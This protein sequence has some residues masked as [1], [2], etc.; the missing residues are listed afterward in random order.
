MRPE[1]SHDREIL[2]LARLEQLR[3]ARQTAR[4]VAVLAAL[5]RDT[6]EDV[7]GIDVLAV[8]DRENRVERQQVAGLLAVGQHDRV[9]GGIV[10][11][12][13][14]TQV[15]AA[16]LPLPVDHD[17]VGDARRVVDHLAHRHALDE[18]DI[19]RLTRLFGDDRQGV[20][21]PLG[22]LLALRDDRL[23]VDQQARTV[24]HA[25][26][27]P[28]A[29]GAVDQHDLGVAA[30][31]DRHARAVDDDVAVA[32]LDGTVVA[33]L[34]VRLLRATLRGAADVEGTHRELRA[35]LADRLGGDD[36]HRLA[37]V[38]RRAARRS[39]P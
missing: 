4:D 24:R 13:A 19:D 14:R 1:M 17:P 34:D 36:A 32:H 5:A 22:E 26:L 35:R 11:G 33:R 12:D 30:H 3:H 18:I 8:L 10:D 25:M 20:R 15:A 38:H 27:G 31:H 9:A 39:R 37:D 21:I 23:A 29:L 2:G 7:A 16:R 28:L 6:R